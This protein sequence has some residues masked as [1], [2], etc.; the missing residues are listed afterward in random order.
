MEN[1]QLSSQEIVLGGQ[2]GSTVQVV[3]GDSSL[4]NQKLVEV[5][6]SAH[7][8]LCNKKMQN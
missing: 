5:S 1:N 4:T 7:S 6:N 8:K 2:Y 3:P